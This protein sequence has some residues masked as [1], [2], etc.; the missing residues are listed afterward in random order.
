MSSIMASISPISHADGHFCP[1]PWLGDIDGWWACTINDGRIRPDVTSCCSTVCRRPHRCCL[2]PNNIGSRRI[3]RTGWAKRWGH[4]LMTTILSNLDRFKK[5]FS[6]ENSLV[7]FYFC[8]LLYF[9]SIV[10]AAFVPIK[11]MMMMISMALGLYVNQRQY[12]RCS[13]SVTQAFM[14]SLSE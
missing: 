9:I 10:H 12:K 13:D 2:L 11:L 3:N 14:A 5:N 4:W 1:F 6:L 8:V 7:N